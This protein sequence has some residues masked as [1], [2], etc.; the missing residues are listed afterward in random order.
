MDNRRRPVLLALWL[1][2]A[3]VAQASSPKFFQVSTQTDFLRGDVENL[4]I[5]NRGQLMLGPAAEL[6][7]ETA[8]PFVWA[9]VQG[10][11]GS[12]FIGSG[13]D[14]RVFRVD[15]QGSGAP[16]F[17]ATELEAHA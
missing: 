7:F 2:T 4:S 17:D 1:A 8:A 10:S 3:A 11:D 13:N 12:L 6:V 15:P 5:D 14:G 16:F 9:I